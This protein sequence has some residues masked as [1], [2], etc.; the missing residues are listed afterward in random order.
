MSFG[1]DPAREALFRRY[2]Q[3][4]SLIHGGDVRP[5]WLAGGS[6]WYVDS[7]PEGRT[8]LRVVPRT[9]TREPFFDTERLRDVLSG[10]LGYGFAGSTVPFDTFTLDESETHV[11]FTVEGR[12]LTLDL[13]TYAISEPVFPPTAAERDRG[14]P[15]LVQPAWQEGEADVYEVPSPSGEW[16]VGA[17]EGNLTLRST[18]DDSEEPLTLDGT[19]DYGWDLASVQWAPDGLRLVAAKVDNRGLPRMPVVRWLK[20]HEA[21]DWHVFPRTGDAMPQIEL[22]AIDVR[23]RRQIRLDTGPE[24]DQMLFPASWTADGAG[25]RILKLGRT[26]KPMWLLEADPHAGATRVL[27]HE[28]IQTYVAQSNLDEP[29]EGAYTPLSDGRFILLSGRSGWSH[30]FLYIGDGTLVTQL[31]SGDFPVLAVVAVD[32][33]RGWV[34]FTAN[35]EERLYD[36]NL[37]RV[38][39][40]GN[41]FQRLTQGRGL[42]RVAMSPDHTYFVDTYSSPTDPPVVELRRADGELVEVLSRADISPL[43]ELGW[44]PPEELVVPAADGETPLYGV[45]YLPADFDPDAKYPVI[46]YIYG[47]PQVVVTPHTFGVGYAGGQ[48]GP[49]LGGTLQRA[50]SQLGFVVMVVDGRGT[51]GRSQAFHDVSHGHFGTTVIPDH[52][53]ALR[54]AAASRPYMDLLRVGIFGISW[55]GYNTLRAMFTAPD[56]Y[57]VGIATNPAVD[58]DDH[59]GEWAEGVMG[60]RHEN[61]RGYEDASNV[62][63]AGNLQ[64]ALLLVQSTSDTNVTFSTTMKMVNALIDAG[65]PYDLI[66]LPEQTHH[67]LGTRQ[68]YWVDAMCRYFIEHLRPETGERP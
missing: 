48:T 21:I 32:E 2:L 4:T 38:D 5:H 30:L 8:I 65:K 3:F 53:A 35:A 13:A 54:N 55:G 41:G 63:A 67:P 36:T 33:E 14:H 25:I 24:R 47:G 39:L 45:L 22:Y 27:V 9:G 19:T 7:G 64:G 61:S 31:T 10:Y 49:L 1:V 60:L 52:V 46:E 16:M 59:Y 26:M 62:T 29:V 18:V 15:R 43:R 34:Y 58:L 20:Q 56:V 57:H 66:V 40:Q 68:G 51:V 6:F 37:Y 42:H 17:R 44:R 12:Q 50:L 23:S 28:P 11:T